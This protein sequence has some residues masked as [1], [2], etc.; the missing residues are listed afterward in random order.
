MHVSLSFPSS[1]AIGYIIWSLHAPVRRPQHSP[2]VWFSSI[3]I[4]NQR[5]FLCLKYLRIYIIMLV[6]HHESFDPMFEMRFLAWVRSALSL[7]ARLCAWSIVLGL[8]QIFSDSNIGF[9]IDVMNDAKEW[10]KW[11]E[12]ICLRVLVR[13]NR[14]TKKVE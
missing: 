10:L 11:F 4:L 3:V 14:F 7:R 13:E 2:L 1:S 6:I 12:G 9:G 5:Y 8:S